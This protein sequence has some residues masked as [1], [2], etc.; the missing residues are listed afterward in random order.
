MEQVQ[1]RVRFCLFGRRREE[2]TESDVVRARLGGFH[3]QMARSVTGN[4]DDAIRPQH[5]ARLGGG[6][7]L[8]ADMHAVA[9]EH[10]RQ[11]RTVVENEGDIRALRHGHQDFHGA[12][13]LSVRHV[14]QPQLQ[15]GDVA[16]TQRALQHLR[17]PARLKLRRRDQ[18]KAAVVGHGDYL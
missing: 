4:A 14:L 9:A 12:R 1:V 16:R 13:H 17:K 18:I 7:V 8:L 10:A 11:V 6:S 5:S 15:R 3:G 2:R